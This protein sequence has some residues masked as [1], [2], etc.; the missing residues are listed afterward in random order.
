MGQPKWDASS[1]PR[2]VRKLRSHSSVVSSINLLLSLCLNS[3]RSSTQG[4]LENS[5]LSQTRSASLTFFSRATKGGSMPQAISRW[6]CC[7]AEGEAD[8]MQGARRDSIP[9][10]RITPWTEGRCSTTEPP[11]CPRLLLFKILSSRVCRLCT[12]L[13]LESS[14]Y[15]K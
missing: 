9:G 6:T 1:F 14:P 7:Q 15:N 4:R 12:S 11:R 2:R 3:W 5:L 10:P 13:F 8:S